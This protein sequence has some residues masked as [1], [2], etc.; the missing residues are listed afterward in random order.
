[1]PNNAA[2][3][4]VLGDRVDG[5]Q[6]KTAESR[7][8]G[9]RESDLSAEA[10]RTIEWVAGTEPPKLD[11]VSRVLGRPGEPSRLNGRACPPRLRAPNAPYLYA[12]SVMLG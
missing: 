8:K 4:G 12:T 1:M 11:F 6:P 7:P 3:R 2:L 9:R 5:I 10:N